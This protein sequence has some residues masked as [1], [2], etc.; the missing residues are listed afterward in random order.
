MVGVPGAC[1]AVISPGATQPSAVL[2]IELAK[3]TTVRDGFPGTPVTA[4]VLPVTGPPPP[5]KPFSTTWPGPVGQWPAFSTR[6]STGP[7][8]VGRPARVSWPNGCP[9]S[10]TWTVASGNGPAAAVTS[11]RV[12]VA[13][14]SAWLARAVFTVTATSA[15]CWAANACWNG[16]LV[17][18]SNAR[19]SVADAVET[20]STVPITTAWTL[21]RSTPPAAVRTAPIPLVLLSAR[22][23]R[24]SSLMP[25]PPRSRPR[26]A[27]PPARPSGLRTAAPGPGRG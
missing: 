4:R 19:P 25:A 7:P 26:P 1:S 17:T 8:G 11:G 14:S 9:P 22:L 18:E 12:R 23:R 13:A 2:V 24:C 10:W 15:P 3:P 6:S 27:R 20:S 5:G 21:C 16:P